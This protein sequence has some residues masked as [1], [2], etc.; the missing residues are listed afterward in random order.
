MRV[1]N[2]SKL[3]L[4]MWQRVVAFFSFLALASALLAPSAMLAEEVKTGK[5]GGLC[6]VANSSGYWPGSENAFGVGSG[7]ALQTG[8][9]CDL[10]SPSSLAL[11]PSCLALVPAQSTPKPVT[12]FGRA[13]VVSATIPG[14]PPGRGP[15]SQL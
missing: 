7:D 6:S 11:L 15:P 14:L 12:F 9:H 2:P 5:L 1:K 8:V 3:K 10:C 13:G 4:P